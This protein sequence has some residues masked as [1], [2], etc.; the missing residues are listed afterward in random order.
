MSRRLKL[1]TPPVPE[2]TE[3]DQHHHE[4]CHLLQLRSMQRVQH[5]YS[6]QATHTLKL[7]TAAAF[8]RGG[9]QLRQ[10]QPS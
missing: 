6:E 2:V 9:C 3:H 10:G 5:C 7:S 1:K 4:W 8:E